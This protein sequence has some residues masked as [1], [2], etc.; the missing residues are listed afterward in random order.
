MEKPSLYLTLTNKNTKGNYFF[1][2]KG[3]VGITCRHISLNPAKVKQ[4]SIKEN[5]TVKSIRLQDFIDEQNYTCIQYI[6]LLQ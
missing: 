6:Y 5:W 1:H 4:A 2:L 3:L